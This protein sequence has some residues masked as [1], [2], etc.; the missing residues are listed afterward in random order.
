MKRKEHWEQVYREKSPLQVSWYQAEPKISLQLIEATGC[1]KDA[2]I[3]DVGGGAYILVD[4][5][6]EEG[7][8]D[9]SVLDLSGKALMYA[10]NRL[11]K[12]TLPLVGSNR[13]RQN[14]IRPGCM[15][16][17]MIAPYFIFSPMNQTGQGMSIRSGSRC[18]RVDIRSLPLSRL[19]DRRNAVGSIS[20]STM[21]GRSRQ[22]L[23]MVS[24]CIQSNSK[25]TSRRQV[26]SRSSCIS[27][28]SSNSNRR[29]P[30]V[31]SF[32]R[33]GELSF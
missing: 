24:Y 6:L 30:V 29:F 26:V 20:F 19:A 1:R 11:G 17:G 2:A 13:M 27:T 15:T 22:N 16:F 28:S 14:S 25:R 3:I 18:G 4:R 33:H 21:P 5:L 32:V 9:V 10:K 8:S 23:E 12:K 31:P 7:Y